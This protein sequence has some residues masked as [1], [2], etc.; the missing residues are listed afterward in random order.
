MEEFV[1]SPPAAVIG[2]AVVLLVVTL[3][4]VTLWKRTGRQRITASVIAVLAIAALL[5]AFYRPATIRVHPEGIEIL[6][7]GTVSLSWAEVSSAVFV[8]D[9]RVSPFRPTVRTRGF[10][11][12]EYRTGRFLLSNRESAQVFMEQSQQAVVVRTRDLVYVLAPRDAAGLARAVD[13]YRV[14]DGGP[15]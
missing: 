7:R 2:T 14:Y 6:E 9:L 8:T 11:L 13:R 1:I 3:A 12:G 15:R 5:F 4:G 10:A